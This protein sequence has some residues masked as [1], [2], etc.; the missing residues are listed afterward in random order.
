MLELLRAYRN[1]AKP[2]ED[3]P[4]ATSLDVR[5]LID[6]GN[7]SPILLKRRRQSH[8]EEE[9]VNDNVKKMLSAGVIEESNGA[10]GFSVVL[11]RKKD[12]EVRFCIDYR[13]LNKVTKRDV[14]SLPRIDE[15]FEAL[16]GALLFT[17]LDLRAGYWQIRRF[18]WRR[19]IKIRQLSRQN[20]V[21]L[22]LCECHSG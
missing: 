16:G 13:A 5:H 2:C 11:V 14:Y 22:G 12:G 17:T 19:T 21:Y 4:P 7:A 9:V 20:K 3:C 15:T 8:V 1:L 18:V 10:W 6:T